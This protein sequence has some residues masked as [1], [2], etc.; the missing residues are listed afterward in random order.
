MKKLLIIDF[1]TYYDEKY[2]LGKNIPYI[3][4]VADPRFKVHCV[5]IGHPDGS[6]E[7]RQDV[8]VALKELQV[9]YGKHLE[10]AVVGAHNAYFDMYIL[11]KVYN[12]HPK[13]MLCSL[14]LSMLVHGVEEKKGTDNGLQSLD[15]LA[16][17]YGLG[18]KGDTSQFSGK[19]NL[20]VED[21]YAMKQYCTQDVSLE[22]QVFDSLLSDMEALLP[23]IELK[24]KEL[25]MIDHSI[26]LYT[27]RGLVV[28][29]TKVNDVRKEY[30]KELTQILKN[31][32]MDSSNNDHLKTLRS[33]KKFSELLKPLVTKLPPSWGK[34]T[35]GV[36]GLLAHTNPQ[37]R[38]YVVARVSTMGM[39]AKEGKLKALVS[40]STKSKIISRDVNKEATKAFLPT[41]LR[42][43]GCH[44]GRTTG[45]QKWNWLNMDRKGP[46]RSLFIAAKNHQLVAGDFSQIEA[47][48][49]A[50]LAEEEL[51]IAQFAPGLDIYVD[52]ISGVLNQD[53]TLLPKDQFTLFRQVGKQAILGL[54]FGL[55]ARTF[56]IQLLNKP[57]LAPA[58]AS[59][60]L[61]MALIKKVVSTYRNTYSKIKTTWGLLQE[62]FIATIN[63]EAEGY[64]AENPELKKYYH[65]EK[66][67]ADVLLFLPSGRAL[68]WTAAFVSD[69]PK[70]IITWDENCDEQQI[71]MS[72]SIKF[73]RTGI[74]ETYGGMLF[75]NLVQA[76]ARDV[77]LQALQTIEAKYK[78]VLHVYD[79]LV[80]EV[81]DSK[82]A[83]AVKDL[84]TVM[85]EVPVWLEGCPIKTEVGA[86]N[87]YGRIEKHA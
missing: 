61:D 1:E 63:N 83:E 20:G 62:L 74:D 87:V 32:G 56:Y 23:A 49:A 35:P 60:Q 48:I 6:I 66:H 28:D 26:R 77:M 68:K 27:E 47:R 52:F 43:H 31:A 86:A 22:R 19:V 85:T 67:N 25:W 30:Q 65:F 18:D 58:F 36:Q 7:I 76:T 70:T 44:T 79:E 72:E 64:Y 45:G 2:S 42:P 4:Y 8:A 34:N 21:W 5:G 54:N 14:V 53:I 29:L 73:G 15:A 40:L 82:V 9:K 84:K 37:V 13:T 59:K 50:Y 33:T 3:E 81:P 46:I 51:M 75:N 78:V 24:A 10:S 57:E 55:G 41:Y 12:I 11:S 17:H 38:N 69:K 39:G 71:T 80:L 16:K